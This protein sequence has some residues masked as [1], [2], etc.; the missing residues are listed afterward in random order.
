MPDVS[1]YLEGFFVQS[2]RDIQVKVHSCW[3][4]SH[5]L[6]H[7]CKKHFYKHSEVTIVNVIARC[8][9]PAEGTGSLT[10]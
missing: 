9:V 5:S 7:Y 8:E 3:Y 6:S 4:S 1:G 2:E 10:M